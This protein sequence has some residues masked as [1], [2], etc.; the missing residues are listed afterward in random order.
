MRFWDRASQWD[1]PE[2]CS[3]PKTNVDL[4]TGLN[5][6]IRALGLYIYIILLQNEPAFP[7]FMDETMGSLSMVTVYEDLGQAVLFISGTGLFL[8]ERIVGNLY[9]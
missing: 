4:T 8:N 3:I 2:G 1:V 9:T 6:P 7:W 5:L